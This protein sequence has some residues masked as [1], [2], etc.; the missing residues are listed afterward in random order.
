MGYL[1][2]NCRTALSRLRRQFL[3]ERG[4]PGAPVAPIVHILQIRRK[5]RIANAQARNDAPQ[6]G[7]VKI[8][9]GHCRVPQIKQIDVYALPAVARNFLVQRTSQAHGVL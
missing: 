7:F 5:G 9:E 1:Y 3:D 6:Y 4:M 8:T 2:V